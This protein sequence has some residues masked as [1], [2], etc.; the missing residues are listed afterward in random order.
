MRFKLQAASNKRQACDNMSCFFMHRNN[1]TGHTT[2]GEIYGRTNK[3]SLPRWYRGVAQSTKRGQDPVCKRLYLEYVYR[4]QGPQRQDASKICGGTKTSGAWFIRKFNY[5]KR[6][7][8]LLN[9]CSPGASWGCGI[10]PRVTMSQEKAK[11]CKRQAASQKQQAS[12]RV[13]SKAFGGK[14]VRQIVARHY[15][16][17]T[18]G[19]SDKRQAPSN[20]HQAASHELQAL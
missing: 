11:S 2:K 7:T 16:T 13:G 9:S 5:K 8:H 3:K 12:S 17:K 4:G 19:A 18:Q 1:Y 14:R 10:L 20:K 15:V 6:L